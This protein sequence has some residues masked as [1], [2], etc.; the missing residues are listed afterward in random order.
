MDNIAKISYGIA[1]W[2]YPDW[3]GIVYPKDISD[4]LKYMAQFVDLIEINNTFYRPPDKRMVSSWFARTAG[5]QHFFFT[6]KIHQDITHG[7]IIDVNTRKARVR[8]R[9]RIYQQYQEEKSGLAGRQNP[10]PISAAGIRL[11]LGNSTAA[12]QIM[13]EFFTL[14]SCLTNRHF[15]LKLFLK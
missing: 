3:E 9:Y 15:C 13:K 7:G 11:G 10:F 4:H 2:S 5:L 8:S 6:A 1:G 12:Q 14:I